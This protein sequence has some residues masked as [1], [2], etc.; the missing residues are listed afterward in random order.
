MQLVVNGIRETLDAPISVSDFLTLK[1][2]PATAVVVERNGA[3][4]RQ[5]EW[6]TTLLAEE[7]TLEILRFVGGG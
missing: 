7:D 6:S 3:I 5:P 4:L 1:G 2:Y